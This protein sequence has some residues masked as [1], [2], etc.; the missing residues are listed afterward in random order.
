MQADANGQMHTD[1]HRDSRETEYNN[2]AIRESINTQESNKREQQEHK[3]TREQREQYMKA[4]VFTLG[5][6]VNE[7]ESGSI[8]AGL[9]AAGWDVADTLQPAD[10]YVLNTCAVTAEA[11]RK[12]RQLVAR[13]RRYNPDARVY[14]CGCASENSPASFEERGV[15][16][17]CGTAG[18]EN[19]VL[20][21]IA[22]DFCMPCCQGLYPKQT[23]TRA[24]IKVQDGCNSFCSYCRIPYLR[25]RTWSRPIEDIKREAECCESPEIV[26]NGI[27]LTAYND[28]G[29]TLTD[30]ILSLKDINARIR[31]GS[32]ENGIIT[33]EFLQAC[34]HL[35]D[36][37]PQF[38]LSLQ[39]GST[40]VLKAMNRHYTREQYL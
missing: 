28:N 7:T 10:I 21:R 19:K 16:Y 40:A 4:V 35:K 20:A 14:V 27:N 13:A 18:K 39:S 9:E 24:F 5:C 23:R 30:L 22:E 8:M 34:T 37:A 2:R 15:T 3:H 25:G 36:F 12:S 11:E 26:L 31:L 1:I 33:E 6:K 17:V 32:L 38:H 29:R